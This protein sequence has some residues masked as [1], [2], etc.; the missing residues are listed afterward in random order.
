MDP[1]CF[2]TSSGSCTCAGSCKCKE[3]RGI[4]CK[5][6]CCSCCH[7]DSAKCTQGC[8]CKG[9]LDKYTCCAWSLT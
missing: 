5:K 8:V 7:P 4:S 1:K 9:A 2:C 6:S 3:C